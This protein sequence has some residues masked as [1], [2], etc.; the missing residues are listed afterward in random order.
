MDISFWTIKH[1]V[2]FWH[3]DSAD[4]FW[5]THGIYKYAY[6]WTVPFD[7]IF[8]FRLRNP[9]L[10]VTFF[11]EVHSSENPRT[12]WGIVHCHVCLMEVTVQGNS[13]KQ[14]GL[15][16]MGVAF[17][18]WLCQN[19]YWKWPIYSW[20]TITVKMVIFHGYISFQEGKRWTII[21]TYIYIYMY[22]YLIYILYYISYHI[23]I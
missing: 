20:F 9:T 23:Y 16:Q 13:T 1:G 19:S 17:T 4:I 22:I 11:M 6:R 2:A 21:Y 8:F 5:D 7:V 15:Q 18:L 3:A 14:S 12:K 10:D